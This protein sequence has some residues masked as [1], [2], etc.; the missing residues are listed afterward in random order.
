MP[1]QYNL[2]PELDIT[3][4]EDFSKERLDRAFAYILQRLLMLDSFRPGIE[5][6]LN[7]LRETGLNRLNEALQPIYNSLV[8]ISQIGIMFTAT[9]TGTNPIGVGLKTF[10]VS[11]IDRPRFAAAAYL[12]IQDTE[13]ADNMMFGVLQSY[14]RSAGTVTV[15]VDQFVGTEGDIGRNWRVSAAATPNVLTTAHQVGAYTTAE[16]DKKIADLSGPLDLKAN[17]ASPILTGIPKAPTPPA[18]TNSDQIATAAFV[19]AAISTL[20]NFITNGSGDALNQFNE[21]ANAI[22]NDPN[23]AGTMLGAL[24]N[25]VRFDAAQGLTPQQQAQALANINGQF[26]LGFTPVRQGGFAGAGDN[27]VLLGWRNNVLAA[28]V[29]NVYLGQVWTELQ[30]G[31]NFSQNGYQKLPSGLILQWGI[32]LGATA[33]QYVPYPITFPNNTIIVTAT[34]RIDQGDGMAYAC[35]TSGYSVNGFGL[36]TRSW[37]GQV[38]SL[39]ANWLAIGF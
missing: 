31:S 18:G 4:D 20:Q 14:D 32:F 34:P 9:A 22:G 2:P 19:Q 24:A 6:Q 23:F 7:L 26:N 11:D 33:D 39:E 13:A 35:H 36:R 8:E 27:K 28:Q 38:T 17:R 37:T 3:Q 30:A 29:D 15:L 10:K 25:R 12:S 1:S 5:E 16:V 21:L